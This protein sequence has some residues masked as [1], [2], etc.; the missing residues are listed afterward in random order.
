MNESEILNSVPKKRTRKAVNTIKYGMFGL[1]LGEDL[2]NRLDF[3][4]EQH[5]INK[6]KLVKVLLTK[7]FD[8]IDKKEE[9]NV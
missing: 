7:Y 6:S 2:Y 1:A 3:Y 5:S 9:N 8:E 4:C